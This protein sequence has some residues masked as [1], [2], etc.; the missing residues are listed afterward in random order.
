MKVAILAKSS[1]S[2]IGNNVMYTANMAT[3][4]RAG[5]QRNVFLVTM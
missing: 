2:P 5:S 3:F 1:K 4:P